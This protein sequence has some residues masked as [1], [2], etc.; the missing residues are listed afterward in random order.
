MFGRRI[1]YGG[2][3]LAM[4]IGLAAEDTAAHVVRELGMDKIR[5]FAPVHHGDT[6]YAYSEVL[7]TAPSEAGGG[8]IVSFRHSGFNQHEVL[9]CSGERRAFISSRSGAP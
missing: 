5:L 8:G 3:T 1:V 2:I 9:V 6:L 4:V 7:E